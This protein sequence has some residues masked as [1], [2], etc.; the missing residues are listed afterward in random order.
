MGGGPAPKRDRCPVGVCGNWRRDGD[1]V[2]GPCFVLVPEPIREA[3]LALK[4]KTDV[5]WLD[6][7]AA[8]TEVA[9]AARLARVL[10]AED[11]VTG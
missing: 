2:C 6:K 5:W 7:Q 8:K 11:P 1:A 3:W 4:G 9:N 10:G